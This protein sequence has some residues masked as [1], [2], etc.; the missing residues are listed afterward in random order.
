VAHTHT[1][2]TFS[3]DTQMC[4]L[5][6]RNKSN[7]ND[8]VRGNGC[9]IEFSASCRGAPVA[10]ATKFY[11]L[12]PSIFSIIAAAFPP[13]HTEMLGRAS[14]VGTATC[15]RLDG[16][17]FE[18]RW[19]QDCPHPSTATRGPALPHTRWVTGYPRGLKRLGRGVSHEPSSSAEVKA[20]VE[21]Y[22]CSRSVP[23]WQVI[24]RNFTFTFYTQKCVS[25]H[26][27]RAQSAR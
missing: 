8:I 5:V 16:P 18:C 19:G 1:G 25:V 6:G 3:N 10:M 2:R 15:Y 17:G 12:A 4:I 27:P 24:G 23:L 22:L 26:M 14:S 13:L 9:V 21:M 7:S 20:R 11:T